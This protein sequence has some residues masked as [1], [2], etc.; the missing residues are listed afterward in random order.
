MEDIDAGKNK[1]IKYVSV[2]VSNKIDP[3]TRI[4][5]QAVSLGGKLMKHNEEL[6]K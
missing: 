4:W 5:V 1:C 2:L 6:E 3:E